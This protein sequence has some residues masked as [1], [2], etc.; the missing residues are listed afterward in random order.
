MWSTFAINPKIYKMLHNVHLTESKRTHPNKP[1]Q[2]HET[3]DL[4]NMT[5]ELWLRLLVSGRVQF[6]HGW[7]ICVHAITMVGV[8][9]FE[10]KFRQITDR[11][12]LFSTE[13]RNITAHLPPHTF[14]V[15]GVRGRT[16]IDEIL[17]VVNGLVYEAL[18]WE[19][20]VRFPAVWRNSG[21]WPNPI[22]NN[23]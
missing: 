15:L 19:T 9:L 17:G 22:L 7:E 6:A 18:V 13:A 4:S 1:N 16:R 21:T 14:N 3:D 8:F 20:V 5:E 12:R 23:T 11:V 10:K 2:T